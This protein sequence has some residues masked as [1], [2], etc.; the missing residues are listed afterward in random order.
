M[1][2]DFKLVGTIPFGIAY[3]FFGDD[4]RKWPQKASDPRVKRALAEA[5]KWRKSLA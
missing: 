1:E 3:R 2:D 5:D 4:P